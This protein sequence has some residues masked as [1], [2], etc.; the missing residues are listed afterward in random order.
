MDEDEE[1]DEDYSSYVNDEEDV[2]E[3]EGGEISEMED[4]HGQYFYDS[5]GMQTDHFFLF[6]FIF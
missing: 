1:E 4:A 5:L 2:G 3:D 6:I